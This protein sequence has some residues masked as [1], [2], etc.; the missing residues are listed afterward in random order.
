M[1]VGITSRFFPSYLTI[2]PKFYLKVG[3]EECCVLGF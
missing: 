3:H 2:Y 1:A